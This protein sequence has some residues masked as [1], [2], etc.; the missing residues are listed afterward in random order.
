MTD[1]QLLIGSL[2]NDL[3]RVATLA[4]RGSTTAALRFLA[5]AKNWARDLQSHDVA[6]YIAKIAQDVSTKTTDSI[7]EQEAEK[8]LM[9]GVLLQNYARHSILPPPASSTSP[10]AVSTV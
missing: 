2:S 8:Y 6:D 1:T 4:H 10:A 5:E 9:Q 3:F 7:S